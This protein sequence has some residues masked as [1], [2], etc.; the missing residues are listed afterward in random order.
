VPLHDTPGGGAKQGWQ[1]T[2]DPELANIRGRRDN[3]TR[4]WKQPRENVM[5]KPKVVGVDE[6]AERMRRETR[7]GGAGEPLAVADNGEILGYFVRAEEYERL[8]RRAF[9]RFLQ[10]RLKGPTIAHDEVF[11]RIEKRLRVRRDKAS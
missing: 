8:T 1:R 6:F 7:K 5:K 3:A 11:R 9:R 2:H 4:L 10:S